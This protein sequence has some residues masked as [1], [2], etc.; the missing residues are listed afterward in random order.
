MDAAWSA[1]LGALVIAAAASLAIGS[2]AALAGALALLALGLW[3]CRSHFDRPSS[4]FAARLPGE[5][6]GLVAIALLGAAWLGAWSSTHEGPLS[7]LWTHFHPDAH[8]ARALRAAGLVA[9]L[10]GGPGS[11]TQR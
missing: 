6:T 9:I 3:A 1:S 8:A 4:L 10:A 11:A 2:H 7:P 5:W